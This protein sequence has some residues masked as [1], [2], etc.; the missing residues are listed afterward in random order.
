MYK[1]TQNRTVKNWIGRTKIK[2]VTFEFENNKD[3]LK[4]ALNE[5]IRYYTHCIDGVKA[6]TRD[7]YALHYTLINWLK[8]AEKNPYHYIGLNSTK[9]VNL[10]RLYFYYVNSGNLIRLRK[11]I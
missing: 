8:L 2:A 5:Q 11:H 3:A 10:E 7:A 1:I 4:F 6:T 9:G